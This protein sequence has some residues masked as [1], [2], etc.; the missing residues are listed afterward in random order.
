MLE[1]SRGKV[2]NTF[3]SKNTNKELTYSDL[4]NGINSNVALNQL[5]Q[6][7][8]IYDR[9]RVAKTYYDQWPLQSIP[10]NI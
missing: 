6:N 7:R 9:D 8:V 10:S 1:G 3:G 4:G 2:P 5:N